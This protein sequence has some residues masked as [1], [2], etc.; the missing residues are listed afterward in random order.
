M[1]RVCAAADD[2]ACAARLAVKY[3]QNHTHRHRLDRQVGRYK[4]VFTFKRDCP[5]Q[6]SVCAATA[7]EA[8]VRNLPHRVCDTFLQSQT[9]AKTHRP[10]CTE[11][12]ATTV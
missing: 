9:K 2:K 10:L 3:A 5:N 11:L 12:L 1:C 4:Y 6:V 7:A 8:R